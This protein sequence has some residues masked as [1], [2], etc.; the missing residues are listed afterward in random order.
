[1]PSNGSFPPVFERSSSP[2]QGNFPEHTMV[3]DQNEPMDQVLDGLTALR[4]EQRTPEREENTEAM[5]DAQLRMPRPR[6]LPFGQRNYS[7]PSIPQ[8]RPNTPPRSTNSSSPLLPL[9]TPPTITKTPPRLSSHANFPMGNAPAMV[10]AHSS[11][12]CLSPTLAPS[13]APRS[14]SPMRSPKR[15]R[16]P[17]RHASVEEAP[18]SSLGIPMSLEIGSISEDAELEITPRSHHNTNFSLPGATGSTSPYGSLTFPRTLRRRPA[19]P[20]RSLNSSRASSVPASPNL[21]AT[22]IPSSA[23]LSSSFSS[24]SIKFNET[25]PSD[26]PYYYSTSSRS[27]SLSMPSTP[28]S[29]RSRSPSISS[30]ET[31]PDSPDAEDLAVEEDQK[32]RQERKRLWETDSSTQTATGATD[33]PRSGFGSRDKR[34]RWSVCGAE[35]RSDL[36]LET[37]WED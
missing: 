11:P 28:T 19:S 3:Y 23:S 14:S 9:P 36:N 21:S 26:F 2:M 5:Y 17:F 22:S 18:M 29:I 15:V 31:I 27:L 34:K 32:D 6:P 25:F 10:R 7:Q 37:I 16:S 8:V 30:L 13:L 33:R 20:L 12:T 1:M 24:E 4:V 35:K